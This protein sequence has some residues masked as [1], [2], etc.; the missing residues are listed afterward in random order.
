MLLRQ[1]G[2]DIP[3]HVRHRL[4]LLNWLK[5]AMGESLVAVR[6]PTLKR[7]LGD[8]HV[9]LWFFAMWTLLAGAGILPRVDSRYRAGIYAL[10]Y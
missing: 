1:L 5:E 4:H 3:L 9:V 2:H 10:V 7:I 8:S 6:R